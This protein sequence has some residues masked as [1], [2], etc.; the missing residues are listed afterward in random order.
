[1]HCVS[2]ATLGAFLGYAKFKPKP[3]KIFYG[4]VGLFIA[5]VIHATWNF[6]L[7]YKSIAPLG[8]LFLFVS[9]II[10]IAAF[11]ISVRSERKIIYNEL[12]EEADRGLIPEL[13]LSI[14]SSPLREK[15]GWLDESIRKVYINSAT[16]LAFR[17]VQ[18]RNSN[19][20]S[21][22]FYQREVDNYRVFIKNLLLNPKTI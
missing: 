5:I 2:T 18:L 15:K 19:G 6:T 3:Q 14:L 7:N 8:F 12:K 16:T 11:S 4:L 1:M 20:E 13:H 17:K 10:F 22:L 21:K 9:I